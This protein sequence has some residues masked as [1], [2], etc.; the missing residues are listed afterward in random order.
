MTHA[1]SFWLMTQSIV[2]G[3]GA[4]TIIW[5]ITR[6]HPEFRY[7]RF[8]GGWCWMCVAILINFRMFS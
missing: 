4:G 6:E 1:E 5:A 7:M 8:L 2:F 3:I